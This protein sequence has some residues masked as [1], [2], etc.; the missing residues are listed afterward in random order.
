MS[1]IIRACLKGA[2]IK[3]T[4]IECNESM[5]PTAMLYAVPPDK[6]WHDSDLVNFTEWL[7]TAIH[8]PI[9][10]R[11]YPLFGPEV[12][13][14]KITASKE[15]DVIPVQDDGTPIFVRYGT[16]TR[17]YATT[18]A[19]ICYAEHLQSLNKSGY[20]IIEVDNA[21]QLLMRLNEDGSYSGLRCTFMYSPSPDLA[22][23][24]T[25]G[26]VNF[27]ITFTPA[28]YVGFG[29]IFQGD[30]TVSDQVGLIDATVF[31]EGAPV[32]TGGTRATATDTIVIGATGDTVDIKVGGVSLAGAPVTQTVTETTATLLAAKIA[33]A[34]TANA[35]VNGGYTAVNAAGVLTIS[36]ALDKG[37]LANGLTLTATVVGTIT[38]TPGGAFAGGAT[39]SVILK[40]GIETTCGEQD[41]IAEFGV[42]LVSATLLLVTNS[43]GALVTPSLVAIVGGVAQLTIPYL[44]DTYTVSGAAAAALLAVNIDGYELSTPAMIVVV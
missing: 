25:P 7:V 31:Q 5:G 38:A 33:A 17:S 13:I 26:Y 37:A 16:M 35:A 40:V 15:S 4:G 11:I 21:N 29:V 24:K 2:T 30:S 22:D 12:P 32:P 36:A 8:A 43:A 41:L 6:V 9:G 39:G 27:Q 28:E 23:F 42:T 19:G 14:R 44:A 18:E 20:S 34:I 3:N 10:Q 1:A